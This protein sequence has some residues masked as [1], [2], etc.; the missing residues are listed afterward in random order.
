MLAA[1]SNL[2]PFEPTRFPTTAKKAAAKCDSLFDLTR[3]FVVT[4]WAYSACLLAIARQR[5]HFH[6]T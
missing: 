5:Y 1:L 2:R 6:A 4:A 3:Q